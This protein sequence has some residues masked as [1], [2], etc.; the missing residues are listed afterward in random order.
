[1]CLRYGVPGCKPYKKWTVTEERQ[2]LDDYLSGMETPD[3]LRK[4]RIS[5]TVMK[6]RIA[7][8]TRRFGVDPWIRH[9][10]SRPRRGDTASG[11]PEETHM[12][13]TENKRKE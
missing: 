9:K 13:R 1:M 7:L 4:Y 11:L 5:I 3:I 6:N 12:N 8:A 2:L 10:K